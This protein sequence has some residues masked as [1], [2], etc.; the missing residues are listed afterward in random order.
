M[1]SFHLIALLVCLAALFS[2]LNHHFLKLHPSVGVTLLALATSLLLMLLDAS[3]TLGPALRHFTGQIHLD[4]ALLTWMLAFLLFAGGLSV[5]LTELADHRWTIAALSVA[6]TIGSAALIG[7]GTFLLLRAL[8]IALPFNTCLLFGALI[9]PTDPVAIISFMRKTRMPVNIRTIVAA[10]SLF[11]DGIGVV[12]FLT[13]LQ[14]GAGGDILWSKAIVLLVQQC[15]G[16]AALGIAAGFLIRL[17]LRR[18]LRNGHNFELEVLL[19]LA[20][21][22]GTYSM[23]DVLHVSGPIAVVVAALFIGMYIRRENIAPENPSDLQHFWELIEETL[24]AVLFLLIG[25]QVLTLSTNHRLLIAGF[26]C[27]PLVLLAR[28]LS[29]IGLIFPIRRRFSRK[30]LGIILTWGG[31]RGGLAISMALLIPPGPQHDALLP[32]TYIVVIFSILVQG[33][34]LKYLTPR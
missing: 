29:V 9:S 8:H 27:I 13:L 22:M 5:D 3:G 7:S 19:T 34:T 32:I 31:L 25:M 6:A 4:G 24:N 26:M 18:A 11:N 16:G 23:A 21:V 20:L 10:E 15:L 17:L 2:F 28:W 1:Q 33:T 30:R 14:A 12:L